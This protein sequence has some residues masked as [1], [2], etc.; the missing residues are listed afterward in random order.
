MGEK[1]WQTHTIVSKMSVL[2]CIKINIH[3]SFITIKIRSPAFSH[4]FKRLFHHIITY[5]GKH[6]FSYLYW[7]VL[8]L[9]IL[10]HMKIREPVEVFRSKHLVSKSAVNP[11]SMMIPNQTSQHF[12][13]IALILIIQ[14][15]LFVSMI[16]PS[17]YPFFLKSLSSLRKN[18]LLNA[19]LF[20]VCDTFLGSLVDSHFFSGFS[21]R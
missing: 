16:I 5:F 14:K 17:L 21:T 6:F 4:S 13:V 11:F 10:D 3:N 15:G 9:Q 18:Y 2:L 19:C 12:S 20:C 8:T 7:E 1:D